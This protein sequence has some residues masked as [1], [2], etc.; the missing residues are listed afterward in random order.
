[1]EANLIVVAGAQVGTALSLK[2]CNL[3]GR[4]KDVDIVLSGHAV[5]KR[6]CEITLGETGASVR[7]LESRNGILVN[8][9][10]VR[11]T[12]LHHG[13]ILQVGDVPL[14][15]RCPELSRPEGRGVDD[16]SLSDL[17]DI[18]HKVAEAMVLDRIS[19]T[20]LSSVNVDPDPMVEDDEF[21]TLTAT[22]P[23]LFQ[24]PDLPE[25]L[26]GATVTIFDAPDAIP[27]GQGH[28]VIDRA[29]VEERL[30]GILAD[31]EQSSYIL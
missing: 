17:V 1:M 26:R 22:D 16:A 21:S 11:K 4:A 24:I 20:V 13:D 28:L 15:F 31:R 10:P 9:E 6:H 3:L 2:P 7:D 29:V 14:L 30:A 8:G 19:G 5:S 27:A 12:S 23:T 18:Q 25:G